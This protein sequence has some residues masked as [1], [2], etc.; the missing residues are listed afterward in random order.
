MSHHLGVAS[1][2]ESFDWL[3]EIILPGHARRLNLDNL[4]VIRTEMCLGVDIHK[5]H[6]TTR[7]H[8]LGNTHTRARALSDVGALYIGSFDMA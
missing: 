7:G 5:F 1:T 2:H 8:F 4:K 3:L 6:D